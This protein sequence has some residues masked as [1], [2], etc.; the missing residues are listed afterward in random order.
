MHTKYNDCRNDDFAYYLYTLRNP[1]DRIISWFAYERP[2]EPSNTTSYLQKKLLFVDCYSNLEELAVNGLGGDRKGA[3]SDRA[4]EAIQGDVAYSAHN[5]YN[6]GY[7][8]NQVEDH[9]PK[10]RIIAIRTEHLME[11][12]N[13]IEDMLGGQR[14]SK[15]VDKINASSKRRREVAKIS[16]RARRNLCIA[17][18][19]EIQV[20]KDLLE[21]AENL[22]EKQVAESLRELQDS[23]P[24]GTSGEKKGE[25]KEKKRRKK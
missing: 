15:P 10:G 12:W 20:Y 17:L 19:Q 9:D 21:R 5:Y 25:G 8:R 11:D 4:W 23:C 14:M 16:D 22:S 7:Y 2:G 24:D 13:S 6:F 3:C 1:V 18:R